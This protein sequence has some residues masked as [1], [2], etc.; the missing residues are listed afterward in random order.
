MGNG[1]TVAQAGRAAATADIYALSEHG[2]LPIVPVLIQQASFFKST[3]FA[4][5]INAHKHLRDGQDRGKSVHGSKGG[6]C[7]A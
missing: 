1:H 6:L 4:S 3:L 5:G 2:A 7:T